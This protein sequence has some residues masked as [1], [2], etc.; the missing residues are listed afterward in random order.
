M[1]LVLIDVWND[2]YVKSHGDRSKEITSNLIVPVMEQFRKIGSQ[3]VHA[4][5]PPIAEKYTEFLPDLT[6]EEIWGTP[7]EKDPWPPE[8]FKNR[9]GEYE[10]WA[11]PEVETNEKFHAIN[12]NRM[13]QADAEPK[14]NDIVVRTGRELHH[15]LKQRKILWL[16][17]AGFAANIC[18]YRRDYGMPAMEKMGY[19]IVLIKDCTT[20]IEVAETAESF[21]LTEA[22]VIGVERSIGYTILSSDLVEACKEAG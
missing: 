21:T 7:R 15:I 3:V 12:E 8:S 9:N 4:P 10:K 17:F 13:I 19:G 1:A 14:D 22:A 18:M 16:F 11:Q 20:A 5:S 6:D 2:I